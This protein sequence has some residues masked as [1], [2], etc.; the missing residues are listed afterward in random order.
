MNARSGATSAQQA[1][2]PVG[3][4]NRKA[5]LDVLDENRGVVLTTPDIA[6]KMPFPWSTEAVRKPC[7]HMCIGDRVYRYGLTG[8]V[9][10]CSK[11]EHTVAFGWLPGNVYPYLRQLENSGHIVRKPHFNEFGVRQVAVCWALATP[12]VADVPAAAAPETDPEDDL[13]VV[14]VQDLDAILYPNEKKK[15]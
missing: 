9:A 6:A 10:E 8:H 1:G 3:Q 14:E 7:T 12:A 4:R 5:I 2:V 11:N 15:R 13:P